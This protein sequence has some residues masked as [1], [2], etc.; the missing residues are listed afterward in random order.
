MANTNRSVTNAANSGPLRGPSL[1]KAVRS[2]LCLV[3]ASVLL[4]SGCQWIQPPDVLSGEGVG[5]ENELGPEAES[6]VEMQKGLS[7]F[8]EFLD[9]ELESHEPPVEL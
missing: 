4:L 6:V 2:A 5:T 8:G 7:T 1:C 3:L 9:E